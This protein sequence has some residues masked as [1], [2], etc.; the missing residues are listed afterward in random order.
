LS[1]A[2]K[3]RTMPRINVI[4]FLIPRFGRGDFDR[5]DRGRRDNDHDRDDR[6]R[7]G[8]DDGWGGRGHRGFGGHERFGRR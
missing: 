1:S 3:Y 5:D 2:R 7:R 4:E 8:D 6:G